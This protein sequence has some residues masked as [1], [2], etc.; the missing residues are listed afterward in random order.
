MLVFGLILLDHELTRSNVFSSSS[1]LF[2][3]T[4]C[5]EIDVSVVT[6]DSVTAHII[7][8]MWSECL[9]THFKNDCMSKLSFFVTLV[10]WMY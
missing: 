10:V 5:N 3:G 2:Q 9:V 7:S 8:E 4:Y 6:G 1:K